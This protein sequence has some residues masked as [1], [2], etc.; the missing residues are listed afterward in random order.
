MNLISS[1]EGMYRCLLPIPTWWRYLSVGAGLT[2]P[3]GYSAGLFYLALKT[4]H[5]YKCVATVRIDIMQLRNPPLN[6]L[7]KLGEQE[8]QQLLSQHRQQYYE[9]DHGRGGG[10]T[11]TTTTTITAAAAN[12]ATTMCPICH[13]TLS[14]PVKIASCSHVFCSECI[15][16]WLERE[17]T[18]PLCRGPVNHPGKIRFQPA[19]LLPVMY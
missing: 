4:L 8:V 1:T 13:D 12:T 3:L 11:T 10:D 5:S 19:N 18:C 6:E 15:D 9:H 16:E 7:E 2:S 14:S 17:S